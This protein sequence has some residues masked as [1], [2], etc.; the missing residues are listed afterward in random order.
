MKNKE[1]EEADGKA[2]ELKR[3]QKEKKEKDE[4]E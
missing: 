1:K 4:E 2:V 3:I